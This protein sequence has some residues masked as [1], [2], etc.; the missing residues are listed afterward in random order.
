MEPSDGWLRREIIFS[1]QGRG[2]NQTSFR[3]KTLRGKKDATWLLSFLFVEL[4]E[5]FALFALSKG[6]KTEFSVYIIA[7]EFA[8]FH[9][10]S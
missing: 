5:E 7:S 2:D 8:R 3:K 4:T 6:L 10:S 9:F 1:C